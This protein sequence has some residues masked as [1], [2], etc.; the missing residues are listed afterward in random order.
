MWATVPRAMRIQTTAT[1]MTGTMTN[2]TLM[3]ALNKTAGQMN[4][5]DKT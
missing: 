2:L 1:S 3:M 4:K 5:I